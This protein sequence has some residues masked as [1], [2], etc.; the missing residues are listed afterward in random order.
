MSITIPKS[1]FERNQK[2]L[3]V[4]R[5][6][7][8][9]EELNTFSIKKVCGLSS[10]ATDVLN[11]LKEISKSISVVDGQYTAGSFDHIKTYMKNYQPDILLDIKAHIDAQSLCLSE[12]MKTELK[13]MKQNIAD[14]NP[15]QEL[16]DRLNSYQ[17][18]NYFQLD[19]RLRVL[20]CETT[21]IKY[22]MRRLKD[23]EAKGLIFK[24]KTIIDT[25]MEDDLLEDD[26][27]V[28]V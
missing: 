8:I 17:A 28:F 10:D 9:E 18:F 22:H 1:T 20:E 27:L 23:Q 25:I 3:K 15:A 12:N 5:E 16:K 4:K 14:K 26:T 6:K 21:I 2:Y 7:E 11:Y 24:I 19:E 13:E